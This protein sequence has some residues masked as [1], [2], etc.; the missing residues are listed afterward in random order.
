MV[1]SNSFVRIYDNGWYYIIGIKTK[2]CNCHYFFNDKPIH[3]LKQGN[4]ITDYSR[5]YAVEDKDR[6][7]CGRCLAILQAYRSIGLENRLI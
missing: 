6:R 1:R 4:Y 5:R 3:D 2:R 7:S